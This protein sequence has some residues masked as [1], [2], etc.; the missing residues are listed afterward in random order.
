[1]KKIELTQNQ[2]AL[3]DDEDYA[4]VNQYNW[5]AEYNKGT[6]SFYAS[7]TDNSKK[8]SIQMHCLIMGSTYVDHIDHD[9]LN[10]Q[11]D[12]LRNCNHS[13]NGANRQKQA[14]KTSSQYKG[15][16]WNKTN[17]K[18]VAHIRVDYTLIYLGSFNSEQE[19][20]STYNK[21]AVKYFYGFA[22]L[23]EIVK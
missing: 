1:M 8:R 23:N 6:K 18:W 19:A 5:H 21:A 11:K 14:K 2:F 22:L 13:Q 10:N 16:Y 15:V 17:K 9:T 12:N 20:A 4:K 7:T 3:V